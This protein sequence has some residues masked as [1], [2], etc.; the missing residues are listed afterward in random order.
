[1]HKSLS[2]TIRDTPDD[3]D[4]DDEELGG[5][6]L[7]NSKHAKRKGKNKVENGE[8]QRGDETE[9]GECVCVCLC[10]CVGERDRMTKRACKRECVGV[11]NDKRDQRSTSKLT[12][13]VHSYTHTHSP[14]THTHSPHTHTHTHTYT[15]IHT[16]THTLLT[17]RCRCRQSMCSQPAAQYRER[18][19]E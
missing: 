1:M 7:K 11:F 18:E 9:R 2:V 13:K 10:V 12:H 14:H 17:R 6:R 5:P 19:Q 15:H 4:L 8:N 3:G 16:H